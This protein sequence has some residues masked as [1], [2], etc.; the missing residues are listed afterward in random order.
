MKVED[1]EL[2]HSRPGLSGGSAPACSAASKMGGPGILPR[3]FCSNKFYECRK[4]SATNGLLTHDRSQ[5]PA[6]DARLCGRDYPGADAPSGRRGAGGNPGQ[7]MQYAIARKTDHEM[8]V[9][10]DLGQSSVRR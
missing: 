9:D 4:F 2:K 3:S 1:S 7:G 6:P 5:A 8:V 10:K